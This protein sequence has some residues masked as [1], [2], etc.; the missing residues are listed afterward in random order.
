MVQLYS[1]YKDS[2]CFI[3]KLQMQSLRNKPLFTNVHNVQQT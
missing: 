1:K 3:D 2:A